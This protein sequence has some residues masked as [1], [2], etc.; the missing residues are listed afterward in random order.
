VALHLDL[1]FLDG[2]ATGDIIKLRE[3]EQAHFLAFR[4]ALT[5]AIKEQVE[6]FDSASPQEVAR[7]VTR[8]YIEPALANI[9]RRLKANSRALAG[10]AGTSVALSLAGTSVGLVG[11]L[12][13]IVAAGV[14]AIGTALPH[15]HKYFEERRD[16]Q[17]AD[18]YFLWKL[19][20]LQGRH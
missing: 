4:S 8:Q 2:L 13:L 17:L 10:K 1:P 18:M 12:P 15:V 5:V 14:A 9:E 16:V 3:D 19:K 11:S 7:S 20:S 6:K